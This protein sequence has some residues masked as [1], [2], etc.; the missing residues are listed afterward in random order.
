MDDRVDHG[1][2][3][4]VP[5]QQTVDAFGTII[6]ALTQGTNDVSGLINNTATSLSEEDRVKVARL[7]LRTLSHD[8][9]LDVV[10]ATMVVDEDAW[11]ALGVIVQDHESDEKAVRAAMQEWLANAPEW[12]V[13]ACLV[14][15][16]K[17][18]SVAVQR[19]FWKWAQK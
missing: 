7:M 13:R 4:V 3:F 19:S 16:W 14:A 17:A 11:E 2:N 18:A 12:T 15:S 8:V 6:N 1:D 10:Y 5:N 9:L